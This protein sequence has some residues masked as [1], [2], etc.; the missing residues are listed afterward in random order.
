[1]LW[2]KVY[3]LLDTGRPNHKWNKM[4][5][6]MT[7]NNQYNLR[8]PVYI[9]TSLQ[10]G[11]SYMV[12]MMHCTFSFR[13]SSILLFSMIVFFPLR[14]PGGSAPEIRFNL[15]F[16]KTHDIKRTIYRSLPHNVVALRL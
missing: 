11:I 8:H 5:L 16:L 12:F 9:H 6:I 13:N 7:Y 10:Q 3:T 14:F 2:Q 4:T 15:Q 1:M